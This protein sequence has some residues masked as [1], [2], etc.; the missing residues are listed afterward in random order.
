M[1]I[2]LSS[3]GHA[4]DPTLSVSVVNGGLGRAAMILTARHGRTVNFEGVPRTLEGVSV[5]TVTLPDGSTGT[6]MIY[7][8]DYTFSYPASASPR[9]AAEAAVAAWNQLA[10]DAHYRVLESDGMLHF[11]PTE[12][13]L[14]D[15][16]YAP[17]KP[18]MD[19]ELKLER[20]TGEP[21][22]LYKEILL[23]LVE[24]SGVPIENAYAGTLLGSPLPEELQVP[25]GPQQE[26]VT[27]PSATGTARSLLDAVLAAA[28]SQ[29]N[30]R[31]IWIADPGRWSFSFAVAGPEAEYQLNRTPLA[32]LEPLVPLAP[33]DR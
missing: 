2:L 29:T 6:K 12:V 11:V 10:V 26:E 18:L 5:Q 31:L 15:G 32:P 19:T 33:L 3:L 27:L 8:A 24:T 30:W 20:V 21:T 1:L 17:S 7:P 16:T 9:D 4:A 14:V 25:F 23:A 13:R 28:G 22:A